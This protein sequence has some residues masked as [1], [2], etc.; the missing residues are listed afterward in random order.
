ML[1]LVQGGTVI[2]DAGRWLRDG[3]VAF[4]G[5]RIVEVGA[6][7]ALRERWPEAPLLGG[8][9]KLVMPGLA[10]AH[11]HGRGAGTFDR[12]I[13]DGVL[14]SWRLLGQGYRQPDWYWQALSY[15]LQILRTGGT[16]LVHHHLAAPA[17][18]LLEG[19]SAALRAYK[20]LGLRVCFALGAW[21]QLRLV[22]GDEQAFLATLPP[23]LAESVRARWGRPGG[24][25]ETIAVARTLTEEA[26]GSRVQVY[27]GP[28][29]PQWCSEPFIKG[30]KQAAEALDTGLHMHLL[31]TPYQRA[32]ADR[33][34]GRPTVEL[35]D[36]WGLVDQRLTGA[37]A[38]WLSD[39]EMAILAR[40]G[41]CVSHNPT[42]NL[43]LRSGIARVPAM[44]AHGI[45]V[46]I[47]LDGMG[48]PRA[49]LFAEMRL[50]LELGRPPGYDAPALD[51][52]TVWRMATEHGT[53]AALGRDD[54]G[55]LEA[56]RPADLL[57]L[58]GQALFGPFTAI[59]R[60]PVEYTLWRGRP[61]QI[62][63]VIV[64]GETLLE[65]GQ[66]PRVNAAGVDQQ[67]NQELLRLEAESPGET[68][69]QELAQ[70]A[71]RFFAGWFEAPGDWG[72][73]AAGRHGR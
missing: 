53:R 47:G 7:P 8:P 24:L 33:A 30:L 56:G 35:L 64:G 4:D 71:Q 29:G 65:Q 49:D 70:A 43:R 20:E 10:N 11:D 59:E 18:A 21:D 2:Q 31:E 36:E 44:L 63:T 13:P 37:H 54:L 6:F 1:T 32:W 73:G 16:S 62:E 40:R 41:A 27:L 25:D 9:D 57:V 3:A 61:E 45:T 34:Y 51:E 5:E 28:L 22:Y 23:T 55:V 52:R 58:D 60:D 39:P 26:R 46:G 67:L 66:H 69:H 48:L 17:G 38:V 68:W 50:A 14:E 72:H 19:A 15:G 12:G 42:S